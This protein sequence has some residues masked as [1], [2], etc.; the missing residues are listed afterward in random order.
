MKDMKGEVK[1]EPKFLMILLQLNLT[2]GIYHLKNLLAGKMIANPNLIISIIRLI[3]ILGKP[4]YSRFAR[5]HYSRLF[6]RATRYFQNW[7]TAIEAAGLA[8]ENIRLY[9][10]WNEQKVAAEIKNLK[11]QNLPLNSKFVEKNYRNLRLAAMYYFRNWGEA[12]DAAGFNYLKEC[13]NVRIKTR[14]KKISA[15]KLA[16]ARDKFAT[17]N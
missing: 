2:I 13:R 8:Y 11:R 4:L 17:K 3:Y 12:V 14:L 5:K 9:P 7:R 16:Y 1:L 10:K 15:E 6:D